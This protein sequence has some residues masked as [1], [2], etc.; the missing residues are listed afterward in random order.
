MYLVVAI[1][2]LTVIDSDW[3]VSDTLEDECWIFSSHMKYCLL[4]L[5]VTLIPFNKHQCLLVQHDFLSV[6]QLKQYY[7]LQSYLYYVRILLLSSLG[8]YSHVYNH[9]YLHRNFAIVI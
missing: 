1:S 5:H 9:A 3:C 2:H 6:A 7:T 4:I 8:P